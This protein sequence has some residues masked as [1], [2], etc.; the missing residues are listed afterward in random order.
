MTHCTDER[1][2]NSIDPV[3]LQE[4][5]AFLYETPLLSAVGQD[6]VRIFLHE[7]AIFYHI[8]MRHIHACHEG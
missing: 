7:L 8:Q 6:R 1:A 2:T 3:L 5:A 4:V